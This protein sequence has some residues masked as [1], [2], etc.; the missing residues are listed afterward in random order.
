MPYIHGV[1]ILRFL[2]NSTNPCKEKTDRLFSLSLWNPSFSLTS[3][4]ATLILHENSIYIQNGT[5]FSIAC[6]FY[7][8][9]FTEWIPLKQ[10]P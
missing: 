9:T 2:L 5:L 3:R 6:F 7:T 4:D 8:P 1:V 10:F